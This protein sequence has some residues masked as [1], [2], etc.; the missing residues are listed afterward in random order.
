M[1]EPD[2]YFARKVV[3]IFLADRQED[4]VRPMM[5]FMRRRQSL[6][7]AVCHRLSN[8]LAGILMLLFYL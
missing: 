2:V 3:P 1:L 5:P 4:E 7:D 6:N 8:S